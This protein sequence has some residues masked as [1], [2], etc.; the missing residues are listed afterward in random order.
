MNRQT[1]ETFII[2]NLALV[3]KIAKKY[4]HAIK[5]YPIVEFE[6]LKQIGTI[7][8]IKACDRFNPNYGTQFSTYAYPLIDGEI[9]RFLR[10]NLETMK[11]SR[12]TKKDY[13]QIYETGLLDEEPE[14]IAEK[15]KISLYRVKQAKIYGENKIMNSLQQIV[16]DDGNKTTDLG[17]VLGQDIDFDT[18]VEIKLFMNKLDDRTR[19]VAELKLQGL[20]QKKIGKVI[21][22]SQ[23]TVSRILCNLKKQIKE[24]LN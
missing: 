11:F 23:V 19:K 2:N 14:I 13:Y 21:G 16:N 20:S 12:S 10:D 7:G 4:I 8:L 15:L 22:L 6:D 24:E 3:N 18:D 5:H 1:R 9:R 17:D